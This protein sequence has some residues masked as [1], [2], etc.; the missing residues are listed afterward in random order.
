MSE[1]QFV[2]RVSAGP[3]MTTGHLTTLEEA[4]S[5]AECWREEGWEDVIIERAALFAWEVIDE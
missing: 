3:A 2:W 5:V 4:R 1:D